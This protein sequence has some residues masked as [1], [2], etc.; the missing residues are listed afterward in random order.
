MSQGDIPAGFV[1][2]SRS[3]RHESFEHVVGPIYCL[4]SE[5][6]DHVRFGFR[7]EPRHTNPYGVLHG[8]MLSTVV[9]TMMGYL[10]F[11]ALEGGACATINLNCD[12]VS[13]AKAGDWIEGEARM[14]R[15][16]RQVA[17][18]RAEMGCNGKTVLTANGSWAIVGAK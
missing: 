12:F 2:L 3:S 16:G 9:D 5:A 13:A 11:R 15:M 10:V 4:P 7:V 18:V 6:K 8:G 14:T 1:P 17:F